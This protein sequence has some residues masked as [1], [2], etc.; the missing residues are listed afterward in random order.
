MAPE[1]ALIGLR[2]VRGRMER[3]EAGI[4]FALAV[5]ERIRLYPPYCNH[6]IV[7]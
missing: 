5:S 7:L 4:T 1:A 6:L 3:L 2:W